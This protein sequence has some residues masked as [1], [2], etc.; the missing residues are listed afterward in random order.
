MAASPKFHYSMELRHA[1]RE[2]GKLKK[3]QEFQEALARRGQGLKTKMRKTVMEEETNGNTP[4]R[5][6]AAPF[7]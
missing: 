7:A 5:K 6:A 2:D 3:I 1:V 4:G